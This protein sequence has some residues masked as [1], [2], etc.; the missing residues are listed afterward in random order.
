M[1]RL[2]ACLL[3]LAVLVP[4]PLAARELT[5]APEAEIIGFSPD[6]RYFAYEQYAWDIVSDSVYSAVFV[7]DRDT[8]ALVE[9]F[10]IGLVPEV[11]DGQFPGKVGGFD[12]DPALIDTGD[13][14]PDLL[15]LREAV[16]AEAQVRLDA[17]EIG[18]GGRRLAGVPITQRGPSETP[19]SPIVF[20]L[21]PTLPSAIPDGQYTYTIDAR[22]DPEPASCAD[23]GSAARQKTIAF[24]VI[25]SASWPDLR[26][27]GRQETP[28][29][30]ALPEDACAGGIWIADIFAP[31]AQPETGES[32]V[33]LFLA[34]M[35]TP[36]ADVAG[37]HALFVALPEGERIPE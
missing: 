15:G 17:L 28:Y 23:G 16:R 4:S 34:A 35:W 29:I 24:D 33:V 3:L 10:P 27:V 25:A 13:G 18:L 6:G 26:D 9:D 31:P 2:L 37:W 30:W 1:H 8:N 11:I 19:S 20:A 7:I 21:S 32:V 5:D 12:P 22:P 36:G 14:T